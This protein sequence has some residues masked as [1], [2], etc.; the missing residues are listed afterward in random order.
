MMNENIYDG[1]GKTSVHDCV[2]VMVPLVQREERRNKFHR[3]EEEYN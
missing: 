1:L 3:Q 2:C